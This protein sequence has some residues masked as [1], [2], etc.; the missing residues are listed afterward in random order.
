MTEN[1]CLGEDFSFGGF[2]VFKKKKSFVYM[3]YI[4]SFRKCRKNFQIH[5]W[6]LIR[7][8]PKWSSN[9]PSVSSCLCRKEICSNEEVF[10]KHTVP[11]KEE[12]FLLVFELSL[13]SRRHFFCS[14]NKWPSEG[15]MLRKVFSTGVPPHI[16]CHE[17]GV[18]KTLRVLKAQPW[19]RHRVWD[20]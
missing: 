10:K 17:S 3:D 8:G 2:L 13:Q 18:F 20:K 7:R 6:M 5:N 1:I 9:H 11:T 16:S 12:A 4:S 15:A 19:L 14:T